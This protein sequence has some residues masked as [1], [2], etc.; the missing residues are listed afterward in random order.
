M[1][2]EIITTIRE[3][4][5]DCWE[6]FEVVTTK[7]TIRVCISNSNNCCESWGH[8][9]SDDNLAQYVGA[10]LLEVASVDTAFNKNTDPGDIDEGTVDFVDFVTSAGKFQLAVYDSHNGYYGHSVEITGLGAN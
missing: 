6:G 2:N 5:D 7:R 3:I 9:A 1:K 10:N 4:I 8:L